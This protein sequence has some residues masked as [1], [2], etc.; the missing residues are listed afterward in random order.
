MQKLHVVEVFE[1]I[2]GEGSLS[3]CAAVFVR[4]TGCNMWSGHAQSRERDATRNYAECPRWCDTAF[5]AGETMEVGALLDRVMQYRAANELIVFTGGEPLLQLTAD[6]LA[7][8]RERTSAV[9]ALETN[10]T[11]ELGDRAFDHVCVSPKVGAA[12]LKVRKGNDLKV[13]YPAYSP[14]S[15]LQDTHFAHYFVQP[16]AQTSAVGVS[17]IDDANVR[18]AIKFCLQNPR[19]RLSMQMHKI[20]GVP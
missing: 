8:F 6:V 19:W 15:Y 7:A 3:G 16:L 12:R 17:A 4:F 10:G 9:L 1:T 13:V 20:I 2:Q 18:R 5:T 14:L 11:V